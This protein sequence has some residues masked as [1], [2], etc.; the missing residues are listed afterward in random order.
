[1]SALLVSTSKQMPLIVNELQRRGLEFP[2]LIGGAAINRRFGRRIL[3]TEQGEYYGPGVFYCKDAFEGLAAMD[4]LTDPEQRTAL[5]QQAQKEADFELGRALNRTDGA[6]SEVTGPQV[7]PAPRLPRAPSWGPRVVHQMPLEAVFECLPK[8]ELFR[9]S[10]GA[11]NT[12]GGDWEK[13]QGEFEARLEQMQRQA[14]QDGWLQPRGVYGYWPAQS[15]GNDLIVY[16]PGSVGAGSPQ[17]LTRFQFPRQPG[18]T[19]L[20]LADYF[21]PV[22]SGK[23]DVVAFQV[24]TVGQ[25]ATQ[26]FQQLQDAAEYTEAYFNH[27]LAVQTAEAAAE[28]L[29]RHIRRELGLAPDQGKR[30]S[31]GYPAIPELSDHARVF[32]LLPVESEL[33]MTLTSAYQLVPEQSTAAIIV[34]HPEARYFS[35]GE[36]RVEQLMK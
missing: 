5:V 6:S 19:R 12:H 16:E 35:V 22:G 4:A 10:W 23:M 11:K 25:Q 9:L 31:W 18:D 2:V 24:V 30:Y 34:H 13:L 8:N 17:E 27:G 14:I 33:G 26:R 36:T 29:H 32:Q 3:L 21:A 28:Y 1:L 7:A 20:S 15:E